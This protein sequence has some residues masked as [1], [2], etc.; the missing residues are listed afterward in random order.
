MLEE[1]ND[2]RLSNKSITMLVLSC[3][4]VTA[5]V[6]LLIYDAY[7]SFSTYALLFG[8][9]PENFG[10]AL[11]AALGG[12]LLYV[13]TVLVSIGVIVFGILTLPFDII[14]LKENGQKWYSITILAVAATA[15]LM[16]VV[17]VA[18]LPVISNVQ[19]AIKSANSS[20]SS[21]SSETASLLLL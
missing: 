17:F 20:S 18:M 14:L 2:N 5:A 7:I 3:I 21:I 19:E 13:I 12:I 6:L 10:E 8:S 11:G 4:F 1:E 9:H 16:A 15:I